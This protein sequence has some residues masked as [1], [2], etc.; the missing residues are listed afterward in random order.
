MAGQKERLLEHALDLLGE[1]D[2]LAR[3]PHAVEQEAELVR[4]QVGERVPEA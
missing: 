2:R 1:E 3:V 4:A